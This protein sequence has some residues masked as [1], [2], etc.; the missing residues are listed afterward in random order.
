MSD[1][2]GL[3]ALGG[4]IRL[5]NH[6]GHLHVEENVTSIVDV[7][8]ADDGFGFSADEDLTIVNGA[9]VIAQDGDVTLLAGDNFLLTK[10]RPSLPPARC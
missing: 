6:G 7:L 4:P 1:V 10:A 9:N 5:I 2:V 8:L 3:T